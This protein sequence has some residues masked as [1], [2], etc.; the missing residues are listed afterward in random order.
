M[1]RVCAQCARRVCTSHFITL[2]S[3]W[4]FLAIYLFILTRFSTFWNTFNKLVW[5]KYRVSI[6]SVSGYLYIHVSTMCLCVCR[7]QTVR[8]SSLSSPS[9]FRSLRTLTTLMF[10]ISNHF[11][12]CICSLSP[13]LLTSFLHVFI[14]S[15]MLLLR[16]QPFATG[17]SWTSA[18]SKIL[19]QSWF[20]WKRHKTFLRDPSPKPLAACLQAHQWTISPPP[21]LT[22]QLRQDCLRE[23]VELLVKL[24]HRNP[25]S[26]LSR[27]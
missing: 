6:Y 7:D 4:Y 22:A 24:Q 13:I 12:R 9:C 23:I 2:F 16:W 8:A 18:P 27:C 10:G 26:L 15:N 20:H 21:H 1:S 11:M 19:D 14:E 5:Y 25:G 17:R 3:S